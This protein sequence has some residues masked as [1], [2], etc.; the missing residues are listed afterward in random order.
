M[1]PSEITKYP[2][3]MP[4]ATFTTAPINK[5]LMYDYP[6]AFEIIDEVVSTYGFEKIQNSG[7]LPPEGQA[8]VEKF[9]N[10]PYW[11]G[12][13]DNIILYF[14]NAKS[15]WNFTAPLFEKIKT[16]QI[17]RLV[18]P[19]LMHGSFFHIVFNLILFVILGRQMENK[20]GSIKYLIFILL[21]AIFSNTTQY[22]MTGTG[23]LGISGVVCAMIGFIFVRQKLAAWEGYQF[24][25]VSLSSVFIF[26]MLMFCLQIISFFVEIYF[27]T[28]LSPGIANTAHLSGLFLGMILGF[29]NLFKLQNE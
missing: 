17:W 1:T 8:L 27:K 16:G 18:T 24:S 25:S 19:I 11:Q 22:L 23:F 5:V 28:N 7:E 21:A 13:Y 4:Y 3:D 9:H 26:I 12:V 29:T 6:K 20:I 10:T 14:Q 2:A 15:P